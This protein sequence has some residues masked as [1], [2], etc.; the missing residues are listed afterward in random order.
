MEQETSFA[1]KDPVTSISN[2][3]MT[4]LENPNFEKSDFDIPR[5]GKI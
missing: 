1:S 3:G 4:G 2:D 5:S